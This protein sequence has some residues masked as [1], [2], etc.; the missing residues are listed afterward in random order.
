VD[1]VKVFR[2]ADGCKYIDSDGNHRCMAKILKAKIFVTP[3]EFT[4]DFFEN[5]PENLS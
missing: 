1:N 4:P 5:C 2:Q 3:R